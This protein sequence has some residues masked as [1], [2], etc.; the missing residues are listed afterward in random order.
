M[1]EPLRCRQL[2]GHEEHPELGLGEETPCTTLVEPVPVQYVLLTGKH[3]NEQMEP[4]A[5]VG[6]SLRQAVLEARSPMPVYSNLLLRLE[7]VP[8]ENE[9]PELYAKVIRSLEESVN[10]YLIQFTSVPAS[11]RDRL[12]RLVR[13]RMPVRASKVQRLPALGDPMVLTGEGGASRKAGEAGVLFVPPAVFC[14][15]WIRT[16]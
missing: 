1:K 5:F 15:T 11:V 8:G 13:R 10:R 3:F 2:L 4:A 6:L 9:P 14:S 16:P 12:N 7:A